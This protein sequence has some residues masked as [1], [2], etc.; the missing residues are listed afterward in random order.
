[1]NLRRSLYARSQNG[2]RAKSTACCCSYT[3][4]LSSTTLPDDNLNENPTSSSSFQNKKTPRHRTTSL[5][6]PRDEEKRP[7][8][9]RPSQTFLVFA[10][11][12]PSSSPQYLRRTTEPPTRK[13]PL[14]SFLPFSDIGRA[15]QDKTLRSGSISQSTHR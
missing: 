1:M 12:L 15:R 14:R 13:D 7:P 9:S 4:F 3:Y 2:P 6:S 5:V 8:S 10:H 11:Y